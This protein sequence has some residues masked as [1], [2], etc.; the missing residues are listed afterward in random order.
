MSGLAFMGEVNE[1]SPSH[2][3]AQKRPRADQR[4]EATGHKGNLEQ[5]VQHLTT[6]VRN[7]VKV[8][9]QHDRDIRELEAWSCHT[10]LLSKDSQLAKELLTAMQ[11]WKSKTPPIGSTAM[12]SGRHCGA[13]LAERQ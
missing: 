9:Q 2:Q 1:S 13:D 8:V 7:L 12:D 10:F 6:Q 4:A 3:P 5:Q 11:A